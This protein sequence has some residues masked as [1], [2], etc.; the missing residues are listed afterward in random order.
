MQPEESVQIKHRL[1]RNIDARPHR[2]I[3]RLAVRDHDVQTIGRAALEDDDQAFRARARAALRRAESGTREK[4]G[5]CCGA[6]HGKA[7]VA[8]KNATSNG[9]KKQLLAASS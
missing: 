8:K 4:A 6:N 2:V 3:L 5:H 1:A 7:A 9:H